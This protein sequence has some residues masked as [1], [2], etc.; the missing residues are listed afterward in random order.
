[1]NSEAV[2]PADFYKLQQ[3]KVHLDFGDRISEQNSFKCY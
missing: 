1:M 3:R 2:T